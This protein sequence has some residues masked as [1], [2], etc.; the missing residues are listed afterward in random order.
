MEPGTKLVGVLVISEEGVDALL[1]VAAGRF[2]EVEDELADPGRP[3]LV[4][5][6]ERGRPCRR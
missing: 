5:V 6:H 3:H 1:E 2:L 4:E